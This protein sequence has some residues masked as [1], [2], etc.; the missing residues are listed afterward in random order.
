MT[1]LDQAPI[2]AV[3]KEGIRPNDRFILSEHPIEEPL[4]SLSGREPRI[5]IWNEFNGPGS[6]GNSPLVAGA[7]PQIGAVA[8]G[9]VRPEKGSPRINGER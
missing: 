4:T 8:H 6:V 1:W 3:G 2:F 5:L 7:A 9:Q